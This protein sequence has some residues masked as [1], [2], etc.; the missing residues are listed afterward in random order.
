MSLLRLVKA[1]RWAHHVRRQGGLIEFLVESEPEI[2]RVLERARARAQIESWP[3]EERR[4]LAALEDKR[5]ALRRRAAALHGAS[6]APPS[7]DR[8]LLALEATA[9]APTRTY[10]PLPGALAE[11]I[12]SSNLRDL[13]AGDAAVEALE[14]LAHDDLAPWEQ[15]E[16]AP[17]LATVKA[18]ADRLWSRLERL[19]ATGM[20]RAHVRKRIGRASTLVPKTGAERFFRLVFWAEPE[21]GLPD[22][23]TG[24]G[25]RPRLG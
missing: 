21:E 24:A 18:C 9:F 5:L 16:W 25:V 19:D 2:F 11:E 6:S 1:R 14:R 3:S 15:K 13:R 17:L 23:A 10:H 7:L 20:A 4:W 22:R 8:M 12:F